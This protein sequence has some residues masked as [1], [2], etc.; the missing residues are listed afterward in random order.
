MTWRVAEDALHGIPEA[1]VAAAARIALIAL[2]D[3]S[4][5]VGGH[6]AGAGVGQ[7]IDQHIVGREKKQVVVCKLKKALAILALSPVD[8]LDTLDTEGLDD[9]ADRHEYLAIQ[10]RLNIVVRRSVPAAMKN[11]QPVSGCG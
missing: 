7:Q 1:D 8:G 9:S 5:L 3:G 11:P 2:H 4:P 6:G 10:G